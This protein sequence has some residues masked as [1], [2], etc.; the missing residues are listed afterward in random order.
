MQK[1]FADFCIDFDI[2]HRT[3]SEYIMK[4]LQIISELVEKD[5]FIVQESEQYFDDE[6]KQFLAD[7]YITY[8]HPKCNH[9]AAYGDQCENCGSALS[10]T[11]RL[12][13]DSKR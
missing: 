10:P 5:A 13:I 8:I 2:Y 7:R 3:S 9:D 4:R 12:P 11:D 6:A 1:A